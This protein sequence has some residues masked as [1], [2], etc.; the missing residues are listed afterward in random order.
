M[1][2]ALS[3]PVAVGLAIELK[4]EWNGVFNG[5]IVRLANVLQLNLIVWPLPRCRW[6]LIQHKLIV[7]RVL[8]RTGGGLQCIKGTMLRVA[9]RIR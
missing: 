6:R 4:S 3:S 5:T 9:G 2:N 8:Y 7:T 1:Q